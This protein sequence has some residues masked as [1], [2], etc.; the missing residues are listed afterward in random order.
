[1]RLISSGTIPRCS[2]SGSP[3]TAQVEDLVL[4]RKIS[5]TPGPISLL[6][7]PA[8]KPFQAQGH[9]LC[10]RTTDVWHELRRR[11]SQARMPSAN[12]GDHFAEWDSRRLAEA[13]T[14]QV[15]SSKRITRGERSIPS[16]VPSRSI[17][18]HACAQNLFVL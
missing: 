6:A 12:G 5:L 13:S 3:R 11:T 4:V 15:W 16:S 7:G 9:G 2:P 14:T 8:I 17:A 10:A 18:L 1:M